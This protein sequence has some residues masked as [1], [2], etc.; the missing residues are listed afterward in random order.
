MPTSPW[1]SSS[2]CATDSTA[3]PPEAQAFS[4]DSIGLPPSP[5]TIAISPAS[6]PCSLSEKLQ[7]APIEPTSSAAG[8]APISLHTPVTA[9]AMMSGTCMSSN[10]PNFD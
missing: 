4:T 9:L 7:V 2:L 1:P 5:G 10:L 8:S 3:W 6:S